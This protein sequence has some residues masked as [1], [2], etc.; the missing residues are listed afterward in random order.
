ML[1]VALGTHYLTRFLY[2]Q[3]MNSRSRVPVTIQTETRVGNTPPIITITAFR[4][5]G[6]RVDIYDI[7]ND[8]A[9]HAM[10]DIIDIPRRIGT[11]VDS[12]T[13]LAAV[14]PLTREATTRMSAFP[15][16]CEDFFARQNAA[17][18]CEPSDQAIHGYSL[19][20]VKVE[21]IDS[22]RGTRFYTEHLAS[23]SLNFL[24]LATKH[25]VNGTLRQ[26]QT[27][28]SLVVG[29]PDPTLFLVPAEYR[30]VEKI[31][32]YYRQTSATRGKTA[33]PAY[34]A[35]MDAKVETAKAAVAAGQ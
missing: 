5:D 6:S 30:V 17:V 22:A 12:M 29:E 21:V 14:Q 16:R 4:S 31:S 1:G 9:G 32:Q 18:T 10:R 8:P 33:D 27:V 3:A 19:L 15:I 25:W 20:K 13:G 2:G 34:L 11:S 28:T 35:A 7:S 24:P 23:P 26:E